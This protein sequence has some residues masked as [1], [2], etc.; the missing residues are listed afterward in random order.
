MIAD[1]ISSRIFACHYRLL[2]LMNEEII[3]V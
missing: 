3:R 1:F 2:T